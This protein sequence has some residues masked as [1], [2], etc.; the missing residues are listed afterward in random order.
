[1]KRINNYCL[2][3]QIKRLWNDNFSMFDENL[4]DI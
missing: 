4:E 3:I 2:K 1:M